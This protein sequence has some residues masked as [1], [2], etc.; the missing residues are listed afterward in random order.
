MAN[1]IIFGGNITPTTTPMEVS[2]NGGVTWI[3]LTYSTVG[4]NQ[5]GTLVSV[6]AGNYAAGQ[7]MERCI[8]YPS[9]AQANAT[10]LTIASAPVVAFDATRFLFFGR[11]WTSGNTGAQWS[12]ESGKANHLVQT[13]A[14]MQFARPTAQFGSREGY[15]PAAGH[16]DNRF[17]IPTLSNTAGEYTIYGLVKVNT[18]SDTYFLSK[19]NGLLLLGINSPS[20]IGAIYQSGRQGTITVAAGATAL[21][22]WRL[23]A[24]GLAS[25]EVNG[26]IVQ[27][28]LAYTPTTL[29][30]A[31]TFEITGYPS[32]PNNYLQGPIGLFAVSPGVDSASQSASVLALMRS[33][34]GLA[35]S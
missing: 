24:N 8:G 10:A 21:I 9:T 18:V 2:Y 11:A 15:L 25:I 34:T 6:P 14:T 28:A 30:N 20:D 4:S 16:T 19:I 26:T 32:N 31:S 7:L 35:L 1:Q 12:D 13:T 22:V 17:S 3:A 5:Q 23:A 33:D 29:N 27:S